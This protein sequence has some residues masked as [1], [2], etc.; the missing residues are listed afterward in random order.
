MR[1]AGRNNRSPSA[2][3]PSSTPEEARQILDAIPLESHV[4]LRDRALIALMV[5]SFVRVS[6]ALACRVKDYAPRGKRWWLRL[7]E[8]GG[9]TR[10][11]RI[12]TRGDEV[13]AASI[14]R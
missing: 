3:H 9:D 11:Q 6:A 10:P 4:G 1:F 8:K 2:R 5:C 12:E 13:M 7:Q 14:M